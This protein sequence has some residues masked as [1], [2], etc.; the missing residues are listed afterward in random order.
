[1]KIMQI[2]TFS[3]AIVYSATS[4]SADNSEI[5]LDKLKELQAD[6]AQLKEWVKSAKSQQ[7]GLRQELEQTESDISSLHKKI[8]KVK[9]S[10]NDSEQQ[11]A[12]LN[13]QKKN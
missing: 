12:D 2:V 10:I 6:I 9:T 13:R 8:S 7:Q 1:M 5:D 11:L 4:V 3:F